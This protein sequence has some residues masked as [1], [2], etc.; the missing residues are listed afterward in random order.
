ME[1]SLSDVYKI[2]L[3]SFDELNELLA[4][5]RET[6]IQSNGEELLKIVDK[7][8]TLIKKI[9][10]IEEK[11]ICLSNNM[12]IEEIV[13]QGFID[14]EGIERLKELAKNIEYKNETNNMLTK[15]SLHF[16][17]AIK[18][19]L[20]PNE[21]RVITYGNQGRIGEKTSDSIFSTK[22]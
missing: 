18:Y 12:N 20:T 4:S 13:E 2:L 15:Q 22:L 1:L 14:L 16:I 17:R 11:R 10:L 21:N 7:K 6:L 3:E 9:S 8:R 5:E 19:A